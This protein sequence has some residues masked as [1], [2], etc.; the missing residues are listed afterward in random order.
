M[1]ITTKTRYGLRALVF[2]AEERERRGDELV[3]IKDISESQKISVQYLE[4]ILYK[5]KKA[6][7]IHGKRGP[8]G[9]YRLLLEPKDIKVSDIFLILESDIKIAICERDSDTCLHDDCSTIYLW[10]KLNRAVA[11]VLEDT[12]LA[13]MIQAHKTRKGCKET[14]LKNSEAGNE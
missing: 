6:N 5:L 9:G 7:I 12:T 11:N 3:R 4:Q 14:L 13:E 1:K 10:N 2:I 8:T